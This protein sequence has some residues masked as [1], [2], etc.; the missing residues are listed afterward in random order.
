MKL[1]IRCLFFFV[2]L[3]FNLVKAQNSVISPDVFQLNNIEIGKTSFKDIRAQLGKAKLI[4]NNK[5]DESPLKTCYVSNF[6]R[7]KQF[8][9]FESG[10]MGGFSRVTRI[11]L[12]NRYPIKDCLNT[13]AN[14]LKFGNGIYLGQSLNDFQKKFN[15]LFNRNGS[16]FILEEKSRRKATPDELNELRKNWPDESDFSFDVDISIEANFSNGHLANYA[17]SKTESY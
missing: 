9:V 7:K 13:K 14:V 17:V 10:A 15:V 8:V 6:A 2:L 4:K 16:K 5:E 12:T 3:N 11:N 1:L